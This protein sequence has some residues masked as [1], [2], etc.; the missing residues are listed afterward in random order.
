MSGTR[1]GERLVCECRR[2][3]AVAAVRFHVTPATNLLSSIDGLEAG[4]W[5]PTP[6]PTM[7]A[8]S[9]LAYACVMLIAAYRDWKTPYIDQCDG[10]LP[11]WLRPHAY[12]IGGELLV[13]ARLRSCVL[14][15][16]H[17]YIG[18]TVYTRAQVLH[19]LVESVAVNALLVALFL[20]R[21]QESCSIAATLLAVLTGI[22]GSLLST[23]GRLL[24]RVANMQGEAR[25]RYKA[26]R[27]RLAAGDREQTRAGHHS[28]AKSA[29]STNLTTSGLF[30]PASPSRDKEIDVV[31]LNG[32]SPGLR[33]HTVSS[34][35]SADNRSRATTARRVIQSV[36][37]SQQSPRDGGSSFEGQVFST[38]LG[39][40]G[41]S[42]TGQ[43]ASPSPPP[44]P[45][46]LA[47]SSW[48]GL[49]P[50]Q[51]PER[52]SQPA[53]A[54]PEA[55]D[56]PQ[57]VAAEQHHRLLTPRADA[58]MVRLLATQLAHA[59]S[60]CGKAPLFHVGFYVQP[61]LP[62][63]KLDESTSVVGGGGRQP[64]FIRASRV[65]R[66]L[67]AR[68]V[69][70]HYAPNDV[71]AALDTAAAGRIDLTCV[72]SL[73]THGGDAVSSG[74]QGGAVSSGSGEGNGAV[75]GRDVP[76]RP[77]CRSEHVSLGYEWS[78]YTALAWAYNMCLLWGSCA[79]LVY[80]WRVRALLTS[81]LKASVR[82]DAEWERDFRA[83]LAVN[84]ALSLTL[85][86]GLK[87]LCLTF[88]SKHFLAA[89]DMPPLK[90]QA[91]QTMSLCRV[92][93]RLLRRSH[94]VLEWCL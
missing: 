41:V 4:G 91:S 87:V 59:P 69:E 61:Q 90:R 7:C 18:H 63:D 92:T 55:K 24:F 21:E 75:S 84:V 54:Q 38:E 6:W 47:P 70:V 57:A 15:I 30:G 2:F 60:G 36:K 29:D 49:S 40:T 82:D 16:Y 23:S 44:S 56:G 50:T 33:R 79:L 3:G 78:A 39:G 34:P 51:P 80:I 71:P 53:G 31:R 68:G 45:P 12:S 26:N 11:R 65:E 28:R 32:C 93:A 77:C 81:S 72:A 73:V 85:L 67:C 13:N 43:S 64:I 27:K 9:V 42:T 46:S 37:A 86:D 1:G 10:A 74:D 89:L 66:Q 17:V 14:R 20:G 76:D 35:R 5:L 58:H 48:V 83:V 52:R 8:L 94:K 88:T 62:H 19:V 22:V 25:H